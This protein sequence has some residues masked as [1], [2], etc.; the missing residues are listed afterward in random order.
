MTCV[1]VDLSSSAAFGPRS[2]RVPLAIFQPDRLTGET[3][4]FAGR[5]FVIFELIG[6]RQ[7]LRLIQSGRTTA[8]TPPRQCTRTASPSPI[9]MVAFRSKNSKVVAVLR[10][11]FT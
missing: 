1:A 11:E 2:S 6:N 5:Q 3:K 10:L 9:G 4:Q 8:L 7:K